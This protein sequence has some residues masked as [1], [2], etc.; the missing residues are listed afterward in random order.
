MVNELKVIYH[1]PFEKSWK[2]E[3]YFVIPNVF[4]REKTRDYRI[5]EKM[6]DFV[7]QK[8]LSEI[9]ENE[10]AN[11]NPH[12]A[13]APLIWAICTSAYNLRD[14]KSGSSEKIRTFFN[15][16]FQRCISTLTSIMYSPFERDEIIHNS[17]TPDEYSF[18]KKIIGLSGWLNQMVLDQ[19]IL[20]GILRTNNKA[21]TVQISQ[22]IAET[23]VYVWKKEVH[24]KKEEERVFGFIAGKY[25]FDLHC[26]MDP[27]NKSSTFRVLEIE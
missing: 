7:T 16:S 27:S 26:N 17:R 15:Q 14:T 11:G 13:D 8:E 19:N 5:F 12:P 18:S 10:K 23:P 2:N 1:P 6:T 22:W 24:P 21:Q 4:Y 25:A 3:G 9:Y 20:E